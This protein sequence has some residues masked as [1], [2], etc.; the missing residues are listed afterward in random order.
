MIHSDQTIN[1]FKRIS[2]K[3]EQKNWFYN[4]KLLCTMDSR[5]INEKLNPSKVELSF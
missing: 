2:V 1:C 4:G 5:K 3:Y